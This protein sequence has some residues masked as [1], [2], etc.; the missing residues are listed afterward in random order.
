LHHLTRKKLPLIL[1]YSVFGA[2][3]LLSMIFLRIDLENQLIGN[4]LINITIICKASFWNTLWQLLWTTASI[5]FLL[6]L[7]SAL[8]NALVP[9]TVVAVARGISFTLFLKSGT[10][11]F[12]IATM[13]YLPIILAQ[14]VLIVGISVCTVS[15][16]CTRSGLLLR[17]LRSN[18]PFYGFILLLC[19]AFSIVSAIVVVI[20][21]KPVFAL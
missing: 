18:I 19:L 16:S 17:K 1:L 7:L 10:Q 3:F 2:S 14:N 9:S 15:I 11:L 4:Y 21:F 13:L 8:N 6:F 5:T 12:G 20:V